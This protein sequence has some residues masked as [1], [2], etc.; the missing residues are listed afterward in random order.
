MGCEYQIDFWGLPGTVAQ[1]EI[2]PF[3]SALY[4][5]IE[6]KVLTY[7]AYERRAYGGSLI[8]QSIPP[9]WLF[10]VHDSPQLKMWVN[11]LPAV[12]TSTDC[13]FAYAQRDPV[14]NSYALSGTSLTISGTNL[15]MADFTLEM[16]YITCNIDSNDGSYI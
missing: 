2:K 1:Y 15:P 10:T 7:S 3:V 16:G 5:G 14:I 8:W 13:D 9:E 11:N 4:N 12:C 6:G